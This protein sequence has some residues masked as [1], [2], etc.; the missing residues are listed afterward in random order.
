[1][2]AGAALISVGL[3]ILVV[4]TGLITLVPLV[5][6]TSWS[7]SVAPLANAIPQIV[8]FGSIGLI[9]GSILLLL[10]RRRR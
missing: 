4:I 9:M 7:T 10:V 1:M 2:H 5:G 3:L 8:G 6:S